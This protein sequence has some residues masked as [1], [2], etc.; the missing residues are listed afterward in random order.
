MT[1]L[2][3]QCEYL[4]KENVILQGAV[5][6]ASLDRDIFEQAQGQTLSLLAEAMD[7][8]SNFTESNRDVKDRMDQLQASNDH[9][10][11]S[12]DQLQKELVDMKKEFAAQTIKFVDAQIQHHG[13][14][15]LLEKNAKPLS[16]AITS[17]STSR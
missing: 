5:E 8:I 11:A 15:I 2:C 9:L 16:P 12:N 1:E 6:R 14:K 13:I 17:S 3:E 7:A 4:Q 10:Q